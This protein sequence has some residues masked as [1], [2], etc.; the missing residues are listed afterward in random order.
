MKKLR[1][2]VSYERFITMKPNFSS[3]D[4]LEN[5]F[6]VLFSTNNLCRRKTRRKFHLYG[7]CE[8]AFFCVATAR[9]NQQTQKNG[10]KSFV[11][12][13]LFQLSTQYNVRW[14]VS[15][16]TSHVIVREYCRCSTSVRFSDAVVRAHSLS[17]TEARPRINSRTLRHTLVV[18]SAPRVGFSLGSY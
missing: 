14:A 11:P 8:N 6:G 9:G 18:Y 13:L 1:R 12:S 2:G 15:L 7:K 3:F 17:T 16:C 5:A 4:L 10:G